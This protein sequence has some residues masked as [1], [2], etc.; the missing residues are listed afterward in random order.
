MVEP[1]AHAEEDYDIPKP[2]RV[3]YAEAREAG[4][5]AVLPEPTVRVPSFTG[6]QAASTS[7]VESDELDIPAFLRRG[8]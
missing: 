8:N 4:T 1:P 6:A 7:A 3:Q 2:L 5:T